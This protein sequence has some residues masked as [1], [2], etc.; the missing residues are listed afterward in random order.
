MERKD[1]DMNSLGASVLQA[2]SQLAWLVVCKTTLFS[3]NDYCYSDEE[4]SASASEWM[5]QDHK[6]SK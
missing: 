3:I 2:F 1:R 4:T 6:A 5:A